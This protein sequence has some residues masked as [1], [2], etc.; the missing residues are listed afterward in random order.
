MMMRILIAPNAF[1]NSLTAPAAA[2]AIMNG[3][4]QSTLDCSC[5]LFPIGDGGDGTCDLIVD[6]LGGYMIHVRVNDPLGRKTTATFGIVENGNTAVIEM[7]KASGLHLLQPNEL[8]PMKASSYGTGQTIKCALDHG[9][10]KL[11]VSVGGSATVDGGAG[12][13]R[14]L[15]I[16]FLNSG[17]EPIPDEPGLMGDVAAIDVSELDPRILNCELLVLCDVENTLLGERGTAKMFGPQKGATPEMVSILEANLSALNA[18]AFKQ[19]GKEMAVIR[20]G[21]AAGG[22]AAGMAMFLNAKLVDGIDEF[23]HLTG[24]EHAISSS[25]LLITAEGSIDEQTLQGKGP[26]GVAQRAR[27]LNVPVIALAGRVPLKVNPL[28]QKY[29]H[30]LLAIG[31]EPTELPT[32]LNN[33][34]LNLQRSGTMIGNLLT[35][36]F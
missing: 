29:F 5:E 2:E 19:F 13:L 23:L 35:C 20:H 30:V 31:N 26:F 33:T 15:G 11:L 1:K 24:F 12:L 18:V 10:N 16:R 27:A 14:A 6:K 7:A 36:R 17:N 4:R 34:Y 21:G 3:L 22:T 28:L 9:V 8:D 25:D 32:A